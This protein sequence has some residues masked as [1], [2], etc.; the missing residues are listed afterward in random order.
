[1]NEYG[2]NALGRVDD[3]SEPVIFEIRFRD[4]SLQTFQASMHY[5]GPD[6]A[7]SM[8]NPLPLAF[9]DAFARGDILALRNAAGTLI[10]EWSLAGSAVASGIMREIC[11]Y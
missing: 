2:G 11:G 5:F 4:G 3:R 9:L 6:E 10:D 1:M 7:W 8:N